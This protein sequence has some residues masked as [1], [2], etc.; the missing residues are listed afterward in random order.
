MSGS[1]L[2]SVVV[3]LEQLGIN[4]DSIVLLPSHDGVVHFVNA[5]AE[6]VWCTHRRVVGRFDV[7]SLLDDS[8]SDCIDV[9]AGRWRESFPPSLSTVAVQPQHER[10]KFLH[11]ARDRVRRFCG[12][13]RH[14][15]T[16]HSRALALERSGYC[17]RVLGFADGMLDLE[18]VTGRPLTCADLDRT[19]I[20]TLSGYL[21]YRNKELRCARAAYPKA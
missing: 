16:V 2:S 7:S 10:I 9:S 5:E 8:P 3:E 13:A 11:L 20:Q 14:G 6:R 4:P 12:F 19:A 17:P 18:F 1:S 15:S 21:V